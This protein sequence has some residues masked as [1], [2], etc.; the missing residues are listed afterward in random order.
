MRTG[1][2]GGEE[3]E[4]ICPLARLIASV[5][6]ADAI[7]KAVGVT[8]NVGGEIAVEA[9]MKSSSDEDEEEYDSGDFEHD[10]D[11]E[12]DEAVAFAQA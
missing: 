6:K 5:R 1:G 4:E 7:L 12:L 3:E 10:E 8:A 9:M 11:E 2:E